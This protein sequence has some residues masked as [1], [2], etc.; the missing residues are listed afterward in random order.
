MA[1]SNDNIWEYNNFD[2]LFEDLEPFTADQLLD[3]ISRYS[4]PAA[5]SSNPGLVPTNLSSQ[6]VVGEN[7]PQN[8]RP[9]NLGNN[10]LNNDR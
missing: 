6:T 9:F 5:T 7:K 10:D 3:F 8:L 4:Q 2:S 1:S